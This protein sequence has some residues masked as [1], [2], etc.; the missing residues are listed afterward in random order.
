MRRLMLALALGGAL[1]ATM[2]APALAKVP[3]FTPGVEGKLVGPDAP[4]NNRGLVNFDQNVF[5]GVP[6]S[7]TAFDREANPVDMGGA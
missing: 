1:L 3:I 2:A 5:Q 7:V 4:A 6:N